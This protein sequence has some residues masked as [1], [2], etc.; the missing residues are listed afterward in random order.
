MKATNGDTFLGGEDFDNVLV[1]HI[2]EEFRKQ[3]GIDLTKDK[4]AIQ[5][6]RPGRK[7]HTITIADMA[8]SVADVVLLCRAAPIDRRMLLTVSSHCLRS[9]RHGNPERLSLSAQ[10][11]RE[12]AEKAKCELSFSTQ[13]EINLPFITADASG[14]CAAFN[15]EGNQRLLELH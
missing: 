12:A 5:V 4:L 13:T 11:L 6:S 3:E 9:L 2:A 8:W 15:S 10:R 7:T 14:E 1:Q